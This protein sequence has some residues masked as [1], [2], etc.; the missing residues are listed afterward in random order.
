MIQVYAEKRGQG[1]VFFSLDPSPPPN[2]EGTIAFLVQDVDLAAG[3]F[4]VLVNI[5]G[6]LKFS[7]PV[8]ANH[9]YTVQRI[10][11]DLEDTCPQWSVIWER[12]SIEEEC[13]S[14]STS[15][16][17][18]REGACITRKL[19][20]LLAEIEGKGWYWKYRPRPPMLLGSQYRLEMFQE[21]GKNRRLVMAPDFEVFLRSV[22]A[23][24]AALPLDQEE[25]AN[26]HTNGD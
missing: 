12:I 19:D 18:H 9:Y 8:R 20:S 15:A 17:P 14:Y 25:I 24:V 7:F 4:R 10:C 2:A 6:E 21:K 1:E 26:E 22:A 3:P 5:R 11:E 16:I 23:A 13:Y